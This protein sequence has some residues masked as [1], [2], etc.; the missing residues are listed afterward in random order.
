MLEVR[1]EV[2][3]Q[4]E[5]LRKDDVIGSSLEAEVELKVFSKEYKDVI[6]KFESILSTIFIVS[7]TKVEYLDR[8]EKNFVVEVHKFDGVKCP[9]CWIY[10]KN[11]TNKGICDKCVNALKELGMI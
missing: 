7:S 4:L 11:L 2:N 6:E 5:K 8:E 10:Y 3:I 1:N 9:R